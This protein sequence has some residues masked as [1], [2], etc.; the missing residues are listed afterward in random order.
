MYSE[1]DCLKVYQYVFFK[2]K[3][4]FDL[5]KYKFLFKTLSRFIKEIEEDQRI[6]EL[7]KI[8]RERDISENYADTATRDHLTAESLDS[9][10]KQIQRY[11]FKIKIYFLTKL[12]V[13][14][15]PICMRNLHEALKTNHH[16]RHYGRLQYV[17]FL[18]GKLK[19]LQLNLLKC[20]INFQNK[21]YW[22][23]FRGKF[24]VLEN[25]IFKGF[26]IP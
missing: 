17:L 4:K 23:A 9:V 13:K 6:S 7:L 24:K 25:R 26:N 19:N 22:S 8:L 15:F 11:I 12:S 21:R 5:K 3:F 2:L 10:N 1:Q 18:K 20:F 14:S 16:L